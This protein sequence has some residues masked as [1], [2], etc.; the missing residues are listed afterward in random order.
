M[1]KCYQVGRF[2]QLGSEECDEASSFFHLQQA[3]ELDVKEAL[4]ALAKI[5]LDLPREL[6]ANY[7]PMV[8]FQQKINYYFLVFFFVD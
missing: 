7:S 3:A 1:C 8:R 4:L 2:N 5:H 6:L